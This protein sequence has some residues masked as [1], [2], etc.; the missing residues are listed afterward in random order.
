LAVLSAA[1]VLAGCG[2]ANPPAPSASPGPSS[3]P[4][5]AAAATT[6]PTTPSPSPTPAPTAAPTAPPVVTGTWVSPAD[7]AKLT[8]SALTLSASVDVAPSTEAIAS[9]AYSVQSGSATRPACTA[10]KPDAKGEWT[11]AVD[12]WGLGVIPGP[13]TFSIEATLAGGQ[14]VAIGTRGA[15]LGAGAALV[16]GSAGCS[17]LVAAIDPSGGY[18]LAADCAGMI[19]YW[20]SGSDGRW[21]LTKFSPPAGTVERAPATAFDGE[22]AYVFY[23]LVEAPRGC[24]GPPVA[25]IAHPGVYYR[26]RALPDGKWSNPVQVGK[27][28][29]TLQAGVGGAGAFYLAV[30]D[31]DGKRYSERLAGSDASRVPLAYSSVAL[32]IGSDGSLHLAYT[33]TSGGVLQYGTLNGSS[34]ASQP[35]TGTNTGDWPWGLVLGAGD[36]PYAVVVRDHTGTIG[37]RTFVGCDGNPPDPSDGVY[38]ASLASGA[39]T[40]ERITTEVAPAAIAIAPDG[41]TPYVLVAGAKLKLYA[42]GASGWSSTVLSTK[43]VTS[44]VLL[45]DAATGGMVVAYGLYDASGG[46]LY[47]QIRAR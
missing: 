9:V 13:V 22:T 42:K 27:D 36:I 28:K 14:T 47:F 40:A 12:L 37:S 2:T 38:V 5:A 17:G 20:S 15:A 11:C 7:G 6:P 21:S 23:T 46:S 19:R 45:A 44:P 39:W 31:G 41:T 32:G 33:K 16:P 25:P 29:D 34:V 3:P 43:T 18:H 30:T 8:K 26:K 24:S 4:S 35:L 10:T 1:L